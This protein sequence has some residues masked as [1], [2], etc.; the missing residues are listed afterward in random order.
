[1]RFQVG[2][3]VIRW[4][5]VCVVVA[6][7]GGVA[8]GE[9]ARDVNDYMNASHLLP[10]GAFQLDVGVGGSEGSVAFATQRPEGRFTGTTSDADLAGG[11]TFAYGLTEG[12]RVG[13]T[14]SMLLSG[15]STVSVKET[16]RWGTTGSHGLA[17][18]QLLLGYGRRLEEHPHV[19]VEGTLRVSHAVESPRAPTA[20]ADGNNA[21]GG[22]A[23]RLWLGGTWSLEDDELSLSG[24]VRYASAVVSNEGDSGEATRDGRWT[25]TVAAAVRHHFSADVTADVGVSLFLPSSSHFTF[26]DPARGTSGN[27]IPLGDSESLMLKSRFAPTQALFASFSTSRGGRFFSATFPGG[28]ITET[29]TGRNFSIDVG[30]DSEF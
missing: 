10:A 11:L 28:T 29:S 20:T 13:T 14:I 22:T 18:P 15:T 25:T 2:R 19:L 7:A 26:K 30:I 5:V 8:R 1:M 3:A 12:L 24:A 16:R 4:V 23:A 9:G 27:D 6:G 17:D 21:S